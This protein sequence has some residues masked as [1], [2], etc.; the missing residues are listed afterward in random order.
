MH[1]EQ[2]AEALIKTADIWRKRPEEI[3]RVETLT[4]NIKEP[5]RR[6]QRQNPVAQADD[7]S[8]PLLPPR[9]CGFRVLDR[10]RVAADQSMEGTGRHRER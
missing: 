1:G 8:R 9:F 4:K 10:G 3:S 7:L 5:G 2:D 6:R